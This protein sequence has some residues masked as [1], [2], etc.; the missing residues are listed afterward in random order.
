M[1]FEKIEDL[2]LTIEKLKKYGKESR[3]FVSILETL[4]SKC[5]ND[6][7]NDLNSKFKSNLGR[8]A[9]SRMLLLGIIFYGIT[10]DEWR[11]S[12]LASLCK[13]DIILKTFLND[14]TPSE[15][16]LGRFL[17]NS[18]I[19]II[20]KIFIYSLVVSN[21]YGF[22]KFL[23]MFIDGTDALIK[24]SK[25]Y[26]LT[27]DE[28]NALI[29][30]KDWNLLHDKSKKSIKRI[31]KELK[32]KKREFHGNEE[33]QNTIKI[34]EKRIMIYNKSLAKKIEEFE[35]RFNEID[36]DY[37]SITF[38]EAVMMPTK[39][40]SFD[41]GLNLQNVMSENKIVLAS[42]LLDKPN[43]NLVL[44]EVLIEL[45]ENFTLLLEMME[46]YSFKSNYKEI[47]RMLKK[48]IY[49]MDSG[50]F[51]N[52]NLETTY[53]YG[54]NAIIMPK[55]MATQFNEEYKIEKGIK[56]PINIEDLD[57]ITKRHFKRGYNEYICLTGEI[58]PLTSVK[59]IN[60]K[61]NHLHDADDDFLEKSYTYTC[62]SSSYCPYKD[63]CLGSDETKCLNYRITT[64]NHEMTNKLTEDAN[65][66]IYSERFHN[67]EGINGFH[68]NTNGVL[69]LLG[70]NK[71]ATT[72]EINLRSAAYNI[73]R[74]RNLK[75]TVY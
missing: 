71:T 16:T 55:S 50:Y 8:K 45:K 19:K 32:V 65:S 35:A 73:I 4:N 22:L 57:K 56:E 69:L 6:L 40:G 54:I 20:K 68:K 1:A 17:K 12:K 11:I 30:M 24:G 15:S 37:I 7:I 44:K 43:D 41:F 62:Q 33:I 34:V 10:V 72:N 39:K 2:S 74:T 18:D 38:P 46:K 75:G 47:R 36:S 48:A 42:I 25:Y 67:S 31:K 14:K 29:Q 63:K 26:T 64:A 59:D 28:L 53:K 5:I 70:S 60:S 3:N 13:K 9:Y 58:L 21:E 52:E 49:V 61:Y 23:H 66:K 27:R 51:S